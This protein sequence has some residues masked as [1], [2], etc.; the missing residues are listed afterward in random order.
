MNR[1]KKTEKMDESCGGLK[2]YNPIK[3]PK[4]TET[5]KSAKKATTK[6]K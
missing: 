1:E 4:K 2:P 5:K 3:P 6:S